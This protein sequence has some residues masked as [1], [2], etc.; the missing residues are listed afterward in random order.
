MEQAAVAFQFQARY[1]RLGELTATT[2]QLWVALHGYGQLAQYFSRKL[3]AVVPHGVCV[4]VPEGLS[5]FYLEDVHTRSQG[6]SQRVGA[7]WMTREN[8]EMDIVNYLNYL[9][10]VFQKET[11]H[12]SS[13][14]PVTVLGFSQGAATATRWVMH[15]SVNVD[16]LI[17]WA[18]LLPH[19][20]NFD[21]GKKLL[22]R[23]QVIHVYGTDDPF[24]TDSRFSEMKVLAGRL[25]EVPT[26]IRFD[27]K[28]ELHEPTL[29]SLV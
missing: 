17:L 14:P 22:A 15:Q 25:A 3:E 28:H 2:R 11:Q 1:I 24:V 12:L 9:D 27:G 8:R 5:R 6:G 21:E 20:M 10:T 29:L 16:R 19:D 13:I 4:L 26:I 7:S 18:G 23:K